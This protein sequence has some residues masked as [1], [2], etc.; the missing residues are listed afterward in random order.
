MRRIE[1]R[2]LLEEILKPNVFDYLNVECLILVPR[3]VHIIH[4]PKRALLFFWEKYSS[5]DI[6]SN[7]KLFLLETSLR[8]K[9]LLRNPAAGKGTV[10]G[11]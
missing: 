8:S 7:R 11:N 6:Y 3:K 1:Q 5:F 10:Q 9:C 4:I 2:I